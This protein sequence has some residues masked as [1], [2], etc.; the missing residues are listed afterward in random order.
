M[1]RNPAAGVPNFSK[2]IKMIHPEDRRYLL[3]AQQLAINLGEPITTIY[4][5]NSLFKNLR[6]FEARILPVSDA[7]GKVRKLSGTLMDITMRHLMELEIRMRVKE[8]TCLFTVSR[9]LEDYSSPEP[10][11]Y[12]QI[13][14]SLLPAMQFPLLAAALIEL[15]EEHYYTERY[16]ENLTYAY[17]ITTE[18]IVAGKSAVN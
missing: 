14:D 12:Q 6:Y 5:S 15:D 11:V 3:D 13:I 18:I 1:G 16:S 8:L 9:L 17:C 2:F 10:F 7:Q 4:R